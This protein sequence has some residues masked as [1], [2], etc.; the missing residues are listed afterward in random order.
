MNLILEEYKDTVQDNQLVKKALMIL[1]R[2][3]GNGLPA[4]PLT[5]GDVDIPGYYF[6]SC[7]DP[8]N[9]NYFVDLEATCIFH[10]G[11]DGSCEILSVDESD[12]ETQ[13]EILGI[14]EA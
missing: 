10:I 9:P 14:K 3:Q 13:S 2:N 11:Q 8:N 12:F 4:V 1:A 6:S 5:L 7:E